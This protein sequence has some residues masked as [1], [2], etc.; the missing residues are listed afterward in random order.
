MANFV[1]KHK[2]FR[3][4]LHIPVGLMNVWAFQGGDGIG[5]TFFLAFIIYELNEDIFYLKDGAY[6]DIAGY[7]WGLA[8]G[9]IG[10]NIWRFLF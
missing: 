6:I 7:L 1:E 8:L 5:L 4:F 10:L 2:T 3:A 9:I